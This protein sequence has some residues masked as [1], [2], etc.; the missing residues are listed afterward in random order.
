[1][2]AGEDG[3]LVER[4]IQ[5]DG[6]TPVTAGRFPETMPVGHPARLARAV[7]ER[8]RPVLGLVVDRIRA[9]LGGDNLWA[10][11]SAVATLSR[12]VSDRDRRLREARQKL[13]EL[14]HVQ[15]SAD[16]G[17]WFGAESASVTAWRLMDEL[18]EL[19]SP[20]GGGVQ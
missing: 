5:F 19:L 9:R 11:E 18:K 15:D 17:L 8:V 13:S 14:R 20:L 10:M 3:E 2:E 6:H 7:V 12:T 16:R 1:M 4:Q